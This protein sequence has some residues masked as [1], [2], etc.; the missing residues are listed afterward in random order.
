MEPPNPASCFAKKR[1][2]FS[3]NSFL[4]IYPA[5]SAEDLRASWYSMRDIKHFKQGVR[6]ETL[7]LRSTPTTSEVAKLA[8]CRSTTAEDAFNPVHW[9]EEV[10]GLEHLV[11]GSVSKLIVL[12]RRRVISR[13]MEE[14]ALQKELGEKDCLRL[15]KASRKISQESLAWSSRIATARAA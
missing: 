9:N 4:T 6:N 14:Q 7:A 15:A 5:P 12:R 13:V 1:V 2:H 3:E 11:S 8:F 10:R